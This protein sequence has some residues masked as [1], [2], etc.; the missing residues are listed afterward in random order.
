MLPVTRKE[1]FIAG[2]ALG[3]ALTFIALFAILVLGRMS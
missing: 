2:C 1:C 3:S